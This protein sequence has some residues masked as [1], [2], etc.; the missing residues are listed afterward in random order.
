MS[1]HGK[2]QVNSFLPS[3]VDEFW[4]DCINNSS[5]DNRLNSNE[6]NNDYVTCN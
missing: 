4:N 5:I 3:N 6:E 1:N 2:K